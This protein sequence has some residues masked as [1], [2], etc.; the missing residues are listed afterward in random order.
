MLF[1]EFAHYLAEMES[2]SS[3][4][5]ITETL[6]KLFAAATPDEMQIIPYL[7][8][9]RV[10]P[11]YEGTEFGVAE[12]SVIKAAA[13]ALQMDPKEV[14]R[15]VLHHGDLGTTIESLRE[16]FTS[17][18]QKDLTVTEVALEF[19]RLAAQSG[20]GSQDTKARILS[21]LFSQADP[22]SCRYIARI[23][24]GQMRLGAS[25]ITMLDALS[26]MLTGNKSARP[27]IEKAYQ[28][29]PDLG[30]IGKLIKDAGLA[31][32]ATVKPVVGTPILM[33]RAERLS[34]GVEILEKLGPC[35]VEP[36]YDGFRLQV[37]IHKEPAIGTQKPKTT[38]A[39]FTRGM[40]N[41]THMYP[42]IVAAIAS[43][44]HCKSCI[45]EG[46]ALGY[47]VAHDRFLPFQETIQRKRK[48]D[49]TEAA[50]RIPLRLMIFDV[51]YLDG[52]VL[53]DSPLTERKAIIHSLVSDT[54]TVLHISPHEVLH[55]AD[56]IEA[57]FD[58]YITD[59]LEGIMAKKLD[60][61]YKPGA[62][63][64]SWVKL[65]KSYSSTVNDTLDCVVMGYD[66]GKGKR[67]AF[68]IG[69]ALLGVYDAASETYKTISK[70][71]TGLTDDEWKALKAQGDPHRVD[72]K[73][74]A[75]DVKKEN[76]PDVWI[77][78]HIVLEIR[79]DELTHSKM[80]TSGWGMRFP[81]LERFRDDKKPSDATTL[82]ELHTIAGK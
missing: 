35:I 2:V 72:A 12:K 44:I 34:S 80:H 53:M 9:G 10:V 18:E 55:E 20:D 52:S 61:V 29:R 51:L 82:A 25:D 42:D 62:R 1:K 76:Q 6:S 77:E 4:L 79:S 49:V 16:S 26:W 81:R 56:A 57:L 71:G 64:Y 58:T 5:A 47:D 3:R 74:E 7:L 24:L 37:H 46:E 41:A 63:E 14:T 54:S 65:K 69:A 68:G 38:V 33:M 28:V 45:L 40:E 59:G 30:Y 22:R 13:L 43:D 15:A 75:Y 17:F 73:P 67:A 36:K 27:V 31:G 78:P 66:L 39:I 19:K 70:M 11:A 23:P 32:I 50:L 21:G 60:S 48:H 8:Q